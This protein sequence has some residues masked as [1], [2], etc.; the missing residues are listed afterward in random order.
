LNPGIIIQKSREN[1]QKQKPP[2]PTGIEIIARNNEKC[3]LSTLCFIKNKPI[4]EKHYGQKNGKS[5]GIEKHN[6]F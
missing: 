4:Q 2:I 5:Q 3:V 1:Q 6:I